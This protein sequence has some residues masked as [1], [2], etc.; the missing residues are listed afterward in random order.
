MNRS[1]FRLLSYYS[2][3]SDKDKT[4]KS[5]FT[6]ADFVHDIHSLSSIDEKNVSTP[7]FLHISAIK[8]ASLYTS[9]RLPRILLKLK[10]SLKL[11]KTNGIFFVRLIEKQ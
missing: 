10:S 3:A 11:A 9:K 6:Y 4:M 7:S 5:I 8:T 2:T 1:K